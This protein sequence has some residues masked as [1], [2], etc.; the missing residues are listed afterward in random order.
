MEKK[1]MANGDLLKHLKKTEA[2]KKSILNQLAQ[3]NGQRSSIY[4]A[5]LGSGHNHGRQQGL[6]WKG[7]E[8]VAGDGGFQKS[9]DLR[10]RAYTGL[11]KIGDLEKCRRQR[12]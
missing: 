9:E 3:A 12:H 10:P 4:Q 5:P 11:R 1:V 8:V 2:E 7:G 6:N